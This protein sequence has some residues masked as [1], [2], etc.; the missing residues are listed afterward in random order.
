M[1]SA[2]EGDHFRW[3]VID[4]VAIAGSKWYIVRMDTC[5]HAGYGPREI[6]A[7]DRFC[8]DLNDNLFE[9]GDTLLFFFEA[10]NTLGDKTYWTRSLG[11]SFHRNQAATYPMEMQILP[12]GGLSGRTDVLYIDHFDGNGAQPYFDLAFEMMGIEPDRF[13][14]R[15]PRATKDNG[16]TLYGNVS[17]VYAQLIPYYRKIIWNTGGDFYQGTLGDGVEDKSDDYGLLLT[18]LDNHIS[19]DGAGFYLSGDDAAE[20]WATATGAGAISLRNLY[21][22][23]SL[24][25][26]SHTDPVD[27]GISPLVIGEPGSMFDHVTTGAD[28]MIAW[29]GCPALNDFDVLQPTGSSTLEMTYNSTGNPQAGAVLAQSSLNSL[30]NP[31]GVVLSGFSFHY[32]VDDVLAGIPDRTEH[33]TDILRW[34]GNDLDDPVVI[35][36]APALTNSLAQNYPNPFNPMT[37]I[38]YSIRQSGHV[39]LKIFAA[40]GRLVKTLVN[41]PQ[42]PS[43]SGFTV[44]W[45][46]KN[47][48]GQAVSSGVYFYK[49]SAKEYSKTKKMVLL[50]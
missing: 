18:F 13:D 4:S 20:A 31:V 36:P 32:I 30:G 15:L 38:R 23:H 45:D 12:A 49:L 22:Q 10:E 14:V 44:T 25:S 28:T 2:I 47:N 41:E 24:V 17:N 43:T 39:S 5:F 9:C 16:N 50:K 29:G 11:L 34:L 27:Y 42:D 35:G 8:V 37:T 33:L 1:G 40:T 48:N 21:M 19:T 46:G 7:P 3:P 26:E 6:P